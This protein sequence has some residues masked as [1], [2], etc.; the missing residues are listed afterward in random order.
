MIAGVSTGVVVAA[1]PIPLLQIPIARRR[2]VCDFAAAVDR[3][4]LFAEGATS[5]TVFFF[6]VLLHSG[7]GAANAVA[8]GAR[9]FVGPTTLRLV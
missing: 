5:T 3:V 2:F 9:H 1:F 7:G 4:F 8:V 6:L